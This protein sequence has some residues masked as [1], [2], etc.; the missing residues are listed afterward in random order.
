MNNL[1]YI[2]TFISILGCG[3]IAGIFFAF[4][5]FIMKALS[6]LDR[7]KGIEAMQHINVTVLNPWFLTAFMGTAAT[8]LISA[9]STYWNWGQPGTL[10][11]LVGSLFYFIG[12]FLVTVIFNV[13]MNNKL[14]DMEPATENATEF[15]TGIY[16]TR[17]TFWNHV[18]TAAALLGAVLLIL[19]LQQQ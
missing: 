16:L 3:L 12:T 6:R 4:S 18:R 13:P 9:I 15:W 19:S 10:Y 17:W 7:F 8:C 11:L 5:T 1:I 14:K 2:L